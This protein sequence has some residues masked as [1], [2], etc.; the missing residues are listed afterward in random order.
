MWKN[1]SKRPSAFQYTE[2]EREEKEQ[3]R[4]IP[5]TYV[6]PKYVN[7]NNWV[8]EHETQPLDQPLQ[9]TVKRSGAFGSDL[10]YIYEGAVVERYKAIILTIPG[11]YEEGN[12]IYAFGKFFSDEFNKNINAKAQ[13]EDLLQRLVR[14]L[15]GRNLQI[16]RNEEKIS[17][18]QMEVFQTNLKK[19]SAGAFSTWLGIPELGHIILMYLTT[20]L[21]GENGK[22]SE[23]VLSAP[24]G[25]ICNFGKKPLEYTT[26]RVE[27]KK[28][29]TN[30]FPT[31]FSQVTNSHVIVQDKSRKIA[32]PSLDL[33]ERPEF[34][35]DF[36]SSQRSS[37]L[38]KYYAFRIGIYSEEG[39]HANIG[40]L[41]TATQ[42]LRVFEPH[43]SGRLLDS[44]LISRPKLLQSLLG[45]Y[46]YIPMSEF[47]GSNGPQIL[48]VL[49]GKGNG[50]VNPGF[51][52]L[53]GLL[54]VHTIGVKGKT[55]SI[56]EITK[57]L[58]E[59]AESNALLI[60]DYASY[61]MGSLETILDWYIDMRPPPT[62]F[63]TITNT[64]YGYTKTES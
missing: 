57:K 27:R 31:F 49:F 55:T 62:W 34:E 19:K 13:L 33:I 29:L 25:V 14:R 23:T 8:V 37:K 42:E 24:F 6:D 18:I 56:R 1:I 12:R 59:D 53:W 60:R 48:E 47:S 7:R 43:G 22:F 50:N 46:T 26:Q 64:I 4:R 38:P 11:V 32:A 39:G 5:K 3:L 2:E 17:K 58:T 20:T 15:E 9:C 52:A 61:I 45:D 41:E 10:V 63:D 30:I 51:C 44:L 40:L 35:Q 28:D 36:L 16:D 54:W 21:E